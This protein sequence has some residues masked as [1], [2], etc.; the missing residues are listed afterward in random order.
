MIQYLDRYG[1]L[2]RLLATLKTNPF[3]RCIWPIFVVRNRL[4][5]QTSYGGLIIHFNVGI[6]SLRF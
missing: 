4:R 5:I 2:N 6:G 3:I 1:V